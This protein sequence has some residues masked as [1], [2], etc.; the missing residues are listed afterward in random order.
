VIHIH[1]PL[2]GTEYNKS[3]TGSLSSIFENLFQGNTEKNTYVRDN[4]DTQD[5]KI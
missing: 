2:A 1:C 4:K 5:N 3:N